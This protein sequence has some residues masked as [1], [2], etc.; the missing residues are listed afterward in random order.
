MPNT[1]N[2]CPGNITI[3]F[4]RIQTPKIYVNPL[5]SKYIATYGRHRS[6][7][8]P[9]HSM[10]HIHQPVFQHGFSTPSMEQ[11]QWPG[12]LPDNLTNTKVAICQCYFLK[13]AT[14]LPTPL[15]LLC[16]HTLF[17]RFLD[18]VIS[19]WLSFRHG[20][21]PSLSVAHCS[22][23]F[24]QIPAPRALLLPLF[25]SGLCRDKWSTAQR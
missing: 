14:Q 23:L 22:R 20:R 1:G 16:F 6:N 18:K 4:M 10:E 2:L 13:T 17:C 12:N 19:S 5:L 8:R 7:A 11:I 15:K 9:R 21:P 3:A 25:N 24:A